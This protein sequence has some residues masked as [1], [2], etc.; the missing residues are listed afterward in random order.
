MSRMTVKRMPRYRCQNCDR[1]FGVAKLRPLDEVA[2][3]AQRI[4]PGEPVPA[5]ECK[6]CGALAH[7]EAKGEWMSPATRQAL[8]EVA[9]AT[10]GHERFVA[11]AAGVYEGLA[12]VAEGLAISAT[13]LETVLGEG[14]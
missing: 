12:D 9:E 3:L 11:E 5:G 13:K 8:R 7:E 4:A 2:D 14:K 1:V 6:Y 10:R